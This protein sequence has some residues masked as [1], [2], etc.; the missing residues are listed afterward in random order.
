MFNK[1]RKDFYR[2]LIPVSFL[3]Y[4]LLLIFSETVNA[5]TVQLTCYVKTHVQRWENEDWSDIND[6]TWDLEIDY[7]KNL[8]VR[9][10][11]F[12][13]EGKNYPLRWNYTIFT[14]DQN[15][16]VAF[17]YEDMSSEK[18]GLSAGSLTLDLISKKLTTAN[19]MNDER[20]YA[21]TLHYGTCF[22]K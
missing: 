15:K 20:G 11:N 9:R 1:F 12:L 7:N 8:V 16:I 22:Q 2:F 14:A 10:R 5:Q 18:D 21:F 19:H 4:P 6:Q 17:N 13:Y 3:T